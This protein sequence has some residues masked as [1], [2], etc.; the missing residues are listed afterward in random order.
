M[1]PAR[2]MSDNSSRY[3]RM[4]PACSVALHVVGVGGRARDVDPGGDRGRDRVR[5]RDRHRDRDRD[6]VRDSVRHR[7]RGRD[8]VRH[9][10]RVR[11][12]VRVRR[13]DRVRVPDQDRARGRHAGDRNPRSTAFRSPPAQPAPHPEA[14]PPLEAPSARKVTSRR[15]AR[16][17]DAVPEAIQGPPDH[18]DPPQ[19]PKPCPPPPPKDPTELPA[20]LRSLSHPL[21]PGAAGGSRRRLPSPVAC[22]RPAPNGVGDPSAQG[23][24]AP[25]P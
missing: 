21:G 8:S 15:Q 18:H 10:D 24:R 19:N 4:G 5:D 1:T 23:P 2:A 6:S 9:R 14:P 22:Q 13:R 7:D 17:R 16:F 20:P 3:T 25:N 12:R 11:V